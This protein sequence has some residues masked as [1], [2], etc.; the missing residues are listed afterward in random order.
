VDRKTFTPNS[1][2][3]ATS[4]VRLAMDAISLKL[5]GKA[6]AAPT[7]ARRRAALFSALQYAGEL[8]LLPTNPL[9]N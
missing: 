2:F 4:T 6:A 8:E 3:A 1:K 9:N 7:V 5:D